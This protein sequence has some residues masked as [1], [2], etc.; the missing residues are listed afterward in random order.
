MTAPASPCSD[1][2]RRRAPRPR[3]G[4]RAVWAVPAV[5]V[6]VVAGANVLPTSSS[7]SA[8]PVLAPLSAAELLAGVQGSSTQALSG[9][10]VETVRLGLPD[11]PGAD[12]SASLDWQSLITGSHTAQVWI[13]GP[14]RQRLALTAPLAE[15]DVIHTGRDVWTYA[16]DTQA[17]THLALP[18]P[19]ASA[20]HSGSTTGSDGQAP[21]ARSLTPAAAADRAL[22]AV[23]PT[24]EVTVDR[25]AVVAD[26][27]V[28]TLVL[29]PRDTRSTVRRVEIAV[30]SDTKV[31][32]QVRVFGAADAPAFE[33]GFT[34][35]SFSRPAASVF[36]FT[37][38]AGSAVTT[39]DLAQPAPA[40]DPATPDPAPDAPAKASPTV[41]GTGW[42]SVLVLPA[43]S[44]PTPAG[45]AGPGGGGVS[46]DLLDRLSTTLPNGDRLVHTAL[47][48]ALLTSDGRVL[49]GAVGPELLTAA[50]GSTR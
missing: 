6:L 42:T 48:N 36:R 33:T 12:R 8:H 22:Q 46:L 3:L 23:D 30:D 10:V 7:A 49:V 39:H 32:L 20:G 31:P 9:T 27:P 40:T 24:T 16:S 14:D 29:T 15:S 50:A 21:D 45:P 37:P 25:T 1:T 35:V 26:R 5:V 41:V 47:V 13:D 38:P 34:E 43:G 17:V 19:A 28:Y 11:L 4:R 18:D 44:L 2:S